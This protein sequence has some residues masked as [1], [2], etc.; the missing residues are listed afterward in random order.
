MPEEYISDG[1]SSGGIVFGGDEPTPI[2][3]HQ[4]DSLSSGG[5]T[6]GGNPEEVW[7]ADPNNWVAVRAGTYRIS[8]IVY[9]L[10]NLFSIAGIGEVAAMVDCGSA[11]ATIGYWRYDLLSVNATKEITVTKGDSGSIPEMPAIPPYQVKLDHV[12]RYYGQ[13]SI[14]QSDIG[15]VY[16]TPSVASLES[17]VSDD[18][19]AW[20]ELTSTITISAY[21]QYG[22]LYRSGVIIHAE[23]TNGN[24]S[25][26]VYSRTTNSS[27]VATFIYT[28]LG[29]AGDSS[30]LIKFTTDSGAMTYV[31]I[32]LRDASGYRMVSL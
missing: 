27:G 26:N 11:P 15:K 28:R 20:A 10:T 3:N 18:D 12:L 16:V 2:Q 23:I 22:Q 14:I 25:L 32:T 4:V 31:M 9:T 29:T 13:G 8:G 30:P 24:G 5:I 6:F 19:L 1:I 17:S 7:M 21:D